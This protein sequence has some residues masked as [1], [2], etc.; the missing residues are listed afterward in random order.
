MPTDSLIQL[1]SGYDVQNQKDWDNSHP[2]EHHSQAWYDRV[3][4]EEK[5]Y[6]M[7]QEKLA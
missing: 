5:E 7:Q 4:A 3:D 6:D 2:Y 1:N